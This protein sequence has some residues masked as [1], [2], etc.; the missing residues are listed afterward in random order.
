[1][2]PVRSVLGRKSY[3]QLARDFDD[4]PGQRAAYESTGN[5]VIL[6]GPGS[7]KTKTLTV[8]LARMAA[9]DVRAPRG[10]ACLT[11]NLECAAELRRRLGEL[12]M[13]GARNLYVGTVHSFCLRHVLL[14][15][16]RLS[17]APLPAGASVAS[18]ADADRI[19][20]GSVKHVISADERPER[21]H[22]RCS[23]YRRNFPDRSSAAFLETDPETAELVLDY[24]G[25]LRTAGKID[26]D[27]MVLE[28]LRLIE[29]HAWV[30]RA[31]EAKFPILAVDEYQDL[32]LPLHRIVLSLCFKAG[33]RLLAVGDPDQSIYGFAGSQPNLLVQLAARP[34]VESIRL[35]FNYRS[36]STI[37]GMSEVA[38]RETRGYQAKSQHRDTIDF[39][40]DEGG[41]EA[42]A[43]VI[44]E[45]IIPEVRRLQPDMKLGQIAVLYVDKYDA[46]VIATRMTAAGLPFARVDP[47]GPY[48]RTPLTRWLEAAAAWCAGGWERKRPRLSNLVQEWLASHR[49]LLLNARDQRACESEIAGFLFGHR[50]PDLLLSDWLEALVAETSLGR[51][52]HQPMALE[53][54]RDNFER[55]QTICKEGFSLHG[56]TLAKFAREE[57][58]TDQVKLVT[59]HSAK[60]LEFDVVIMMGM[61]QGRMPKFSAETGEGLREQR[62]LFYVG[63]TR[64]RH[65]V[66]MTFSGWYR[67]PTGRIWQKGASQFVIEIYQRMQ[68]AS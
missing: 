24:E 18:S 1:M 65:A 64:A 15:Y 9:E 2:S 8:K 26:F 33:I 10:I 53:D 49:P 34:D 52:L 14:P 25:R 29:K 37:V 35:E 13:D 4:N 5:C 68:T 27:M 47:G 41:I 38:L 40:E 60:G 50:Q 11:Y 3:R 61:D 48:P 20:S 17:D 22:T 46:E 57:G 36:G 59:L 39:H 62:R 66:H 31:I 12:G 28:G 43:S 19:F 51:A 58:V 30:R 42:Q 45:K 32:G 7:G 56:A 16:S 63:L 54:E 23:T 67:G 55:L 21:F 6:A 44:C